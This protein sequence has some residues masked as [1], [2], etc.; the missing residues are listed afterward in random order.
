MTETDILSLI[1]KKFPEE[2][3]AVLPQVRNGTGYERSARTA[4]AMVMGLW[5]S[6]G[7]ELEGFEIKVSRADWLRELKKPQKAEDIF[8]Y[9]D[10]WWVV[11]ADRDIVKDGELPPTWG[12]MVTGDRGL[13]VKVIAPKL[14]PKPMDRLMLAAILRKVQAYSTDNATLT[15]AKDAAFDRGHA[16]GCK[17]ADEVE[18]RLADLNKAVN[19]FEQAS[20]VPI[21]HAWDHGNIG[22]AVKMVRSGAFNNGRER[23]H[24]VVDSAR[25]LADEGAKELA[26]LD[27]LC[28]L[29]DIPVSQTPMEA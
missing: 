27:S 20:G 29:S 8:G 26:V 22:Q 14:T 16:E 19:I 15:K 7:M 4:D 10:R 17:L 6:R 12:L 21:R 24:N 23:L 3:Y 28:P 13:L 2:A 25:R 11:V 1:K 18:R 5:P 9:C